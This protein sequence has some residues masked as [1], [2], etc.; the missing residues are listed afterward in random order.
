MA[1]IDLSG[2]SMS[3]NSL[4]GSKYNHAC[5]QKTGESTKHQDTDL[6]NMD[7]DYDNK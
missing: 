2:N 7:L 3:N 6:S 5:F 4:I 1:S